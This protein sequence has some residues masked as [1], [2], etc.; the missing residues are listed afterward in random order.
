MPLE[1]DYTGEYDLDDHLNAIISYWKLNNQNVFE[2][3]RSFTVSNPMLR[4]VRELDNTVVS[5]F[6]YPSSCGKKLFF[7]FKDKV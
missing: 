1:K 2:C 3:Y 7:F 6:L 4:Q 5:T